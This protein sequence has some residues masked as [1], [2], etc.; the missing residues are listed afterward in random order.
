ME[1]LTTSAISTLIDGF[2]SAIAAGSVNVI[3]VEAIRERSGERWPRKREQVESFV[4]R[5]F[6]KQAGACV[7]VA[8]LNEVEF[9]SIQPD[10]SRLEA[11]GHSAA[12]LKETL[13]FFLGK[14]DGQDVRILQVTGHA[15]GDLSVE[16]VDCSRWLDASAP[17]SGAVEASEPPAQAPLPAVQLDQL[18]WAGTQT[19]RIALAPIWNI[20]QEVVAS[21]LMQPT[22]YLT[23]SLERVEPSPL[24][25]EQLVSAGI[26]QARAWLSE[27]GARGT[28]FALHLPLPFLG[29]SSTNARY[30]VQRQLTDMPAE[31]RKLV[32]LDLMG[33]EEG[34]PYAR[35]AET[36]SALKPFC[37]AVLARA[38]SPAAKLAQWRNCRLDGV[39]LD[40]HALD[41]GDRMSMAR[42]A[43]FA[44]E[45]GKVSRTIV[46]Y[47]LANRS[48][49]LAAWAAGFSHV[50]G[51]AVQPM[52][53][54]RAV[55]WDGAD[56][57]GA[58]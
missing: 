40:C 52:A 24:A 31:L 9:L 55:R 13:S 21:F 17:P 1:R 25:A 34:V 27:A 6:L 46:G 32:V 18:A 33:I 10:A 16:P 47:G 23:S 2:S 37:R 57:Y 36:V 56:L 19:S 11:L 8:A 5:A 48:L 15:A 3:S 4:E 53:K 38:A 42:L 22:V 7:I 12:V 39:T 51:D 35:M 43:S 26:G 20:A 49:T 45:A 54:P 30:R 50:T 14:V 58:A 44:D 28:R 29:V 41:P